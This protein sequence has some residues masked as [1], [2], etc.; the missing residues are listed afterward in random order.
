[1]LGVAWE[2]KTV[3]PMFTAAAPRVIEAAATL[4]HVSNLYHSPPQIHLAKLLTEHSFADRV[5]FANSGAEANEAAIKL[6]RRHGGDR[7]GIVGVEGAFHGRTLGAL[8]ATW[9]AAKQDP[10]RPLPD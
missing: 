3:W 4:L 5:F 6:A 9:G 7:R 2:T 8:A 1:M 10:F